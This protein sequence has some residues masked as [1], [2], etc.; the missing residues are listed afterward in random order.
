M[1]VK[2]IRLIVFAITVMNI[3][4]GKSRLFMKP[5]FWIMENVEDPK[6]AV[7]GFHQDDWT[8]ESRPPQDKVDSKDPIGP[9]LVPI[10]L[11]NTPSP[12]AQEP[13]LMMFPNG[14][15]YKGSPDN[16]VSISRIPGLTQIFSKGY[17]MD[18]SI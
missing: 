7:L 3:K 15:Y 18:S 8:I 6:D 2:N 1:K 12:V 17:S 13:R 9:K 4:L 5:N 11:K 10:S 16:T 14:K